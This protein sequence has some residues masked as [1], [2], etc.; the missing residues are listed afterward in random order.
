ML[1]VAVLGVSAGQTGG[2]PWP[3]TLHLSAQICVERPGDNGALNIRL[4]D[5][6]IGD[7]GPILSLMGEQAACAYVEP[8]RYSVHAQSRDPYDPA[9]KNP[10]KWKS[11]SLT[12]VATAG[13]RVMLEVCGTGAR[14]YSNWKV[15]RSGPECR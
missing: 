6:V 5:V 4:A 7:A 2:Q 8:G 1:I 12:V 3:K 14:G 11:A 13:E 9:S 10:A 15:Q